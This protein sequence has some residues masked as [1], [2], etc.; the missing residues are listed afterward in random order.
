MITI[1]KSTVWN[2]KKFEV[3]FQNGNVQR[4]SRESEAVA[5]AGN[6]RKDGEEI[7]N[8]VVKETKVKFN[9]NWQ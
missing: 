3:T 9:K 7:V 1:Q 2:K 8:K 5:F 6:N 4:F